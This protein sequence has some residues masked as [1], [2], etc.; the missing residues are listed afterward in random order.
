MAELTPEAK[1]EIAAAVKIVREDSVDKL[2]RKHLSTKTTDPKDPPTPASTST[3]NPPVPTTTG[4]NPPPT[5]SSP[6]DSPP[7]PD[8]AP[9]KS[10]YWGDGLFAE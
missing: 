4:P 2:L 5:N 6:N 1:A 7:P 10:L 3:S 9:K 8:P